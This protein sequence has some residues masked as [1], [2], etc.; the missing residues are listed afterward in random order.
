MAKLGAFWGGI[1]GVLFRSASSGFLAW[2][3]C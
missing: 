3:R 1:W 2:G